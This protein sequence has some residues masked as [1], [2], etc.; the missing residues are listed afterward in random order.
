M[1]AIRLTDAAGHP[2]HPGAAVE[3]D[4]MAPYSTLQAKERFEEESLTTS[5]I[6]NP[7]MTVG[8]NG[9]LK[10]QLEP[11]LKSGRALLIIKTKNGEREVRAW[12]KP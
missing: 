2:L 3:L 12:L 4:V 5:N 10:V 1:V 6:V 9:I 7:G 11:T 8:E